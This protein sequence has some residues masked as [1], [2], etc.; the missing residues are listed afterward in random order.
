MVHVT[1]SAEI[2][3][4]LK[5]SSFI[6]VASRVGHS[7]LIPG[8]L[9]TLDGLEH[10]Q[11]RRIESKLFRPDRIEYYRQAA[12]L[13]SM[14]AAMD[15]L[16]SLKDASGVVRTDLV[17]LT[18]RMAQAI[19]AVLAGIDGAGDAAGA[20]TLT[21]YVKDI[22]AA[23]TIGWQVGDHEEILRRG[24]E[25]RAALRRD[26]FDSSV[27]RRRNLLAEVRA[28]RRAAGD[29][30][31]DLISLLL[32]NLRPDE[33]AGTILAE[34]MMFLMASITTTAGAF[35]HFIV[36]LLDWMA[37]HPEYRPELVNQD[38]I[39]RAV[40][41]SLRFFVA[42]PARLREARE[43]CLLAST[44]RRVTA[45]AKFA[46]WFVPANMEAA[47]FG[48]DA[49]EFNPLREDGRNRPWGLAFGA[50]PHSCI[51]RT[52]IT[53]FPR[54]TADGGSAHVYGTMTTLALHLFEAGLEIDPDSPPRLT[55]ST[56]YDEY[57]SLPV[58]LTA[59]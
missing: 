50:G 33:D 13:P 38:F 40:N 16:R 11:R 37:D 44:G 17:P 5:S 27:A 39:Q 30:P 22:A 57:V 4:I 45:G 32:Q 20:A 55:S 49:L 31:R 14:A 19:P 24:L 47:T 10:S 58:T 9:S 36:R 8:A 51:G 59:L 43:D 6:Q 42:S 52:V 41:E 12:L 28:G 56:F 26:F 29:V 48:P 25:A 34:T 23:V 2:E 54:R 3:E 15:E 18:W 35:P 21:T 53:G 46:L 7:Q 1:D